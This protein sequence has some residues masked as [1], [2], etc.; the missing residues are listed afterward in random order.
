MKTAAIQTSTCQRD[1][2]LSR[3]VMSSACRTR[4][5]AVFGLMR[6]HPLLWNGEFPGKIRP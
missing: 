3:L 4:F 2:S 5:G 6:A 1:V